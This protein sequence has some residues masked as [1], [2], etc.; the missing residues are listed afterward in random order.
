MANLLLAFIAKTYDILKLR[1]T[2][3]KSAY[4]VTEFTIFIQFLLA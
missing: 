3:V 4:C 1:G 2:L